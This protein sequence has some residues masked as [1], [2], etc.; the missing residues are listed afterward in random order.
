MNQFILARNPFYYQHGLVAS[1][2]VALGLF[3]KENQSI[4]E[5]ALKYCLYSYPLLAL[6]NFW[7]SPN[8]TASLSVSLK[9]IPLFL[10]LS[11]CGTLFLIVICKKIKKCS[12]LEFWGQNSLVVYALHFA[13][14]VY[15]FKLFYAWIQPISILSFVGALLLLLTTEYM[16]CCLLMKLFQYKPFKWLLGRY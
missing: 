1:F 11:V 2:F 16:L 6:I 5:K 15:F 8:I 12:F 14:L 3:L 9:T 10:I 4:Y 13:P 7:R